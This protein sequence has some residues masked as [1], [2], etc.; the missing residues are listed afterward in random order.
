MKN[1]S[2]QDRYA[3][4]RNLSRTDLFFL[5]VY[6]LK[7]ADADN[8]WVFARCREMQAEPNGYLDLWAREHYKSSIITF[9]LTIQD[10]LNNPDLTVGIFSH[11]RPIAKGFLRQIKSEFERNELLKEWFPDILWADPRKEAPKWSEDEG[12]VVKRQSNPKE[13][14]IEAWGLVDGQPTS[15]HFKLCV[16]DDVVTRE[17]VTTPDMIGKVTEAWELSRN[18]T[19]AGGASRYIGTRYHF[20]DTYKTILDRGAAKPRVY[21]ATID[22]TVNGQPV[23]LSAE[24]LA[25]KRRE[26]GPHT[27]GCLPG[28]APVLMADFREKP[29]SEIKAGDSVVGYEFPPRA[30]TR[31]RPAKVLAV[32]NRRAELLEFSLASG[33]KVTCTAQHKWYTG[34]RGKD[35]GGSDTHNAYAPL[36]NGARP[37]IGG[38]TSH[39]VSLYDPRQVHTPYDERAAAWLGGFYD[40]EGS[41]SG[42]SVHFHQSEKYPDILDRLERELQACDFKFGMSRAERRPGWSPARDYYLRGGRTEHIRFLNIARPAKAAAIVKALFERDAR[43]FNGAKKN[44]DK[45][46]SVRSLGVGKVFNMET[47]TGNY[48]AYGYATKNSQML[49]NPKADETQGFKTEWLRHYGHTRREGVNVCIL[50]DSASE[51]KKSSDYTSMWVLGLNEDQNIYAL[52]MVRDRLNLSQRAQALFGLHRKWMPLAVGY[53]KYGMMADVEFMRHEMERIN[54]RFPIAELGGQMPK[55]DR[56]KRLVPYFEQGRLYLPNHLHRTDYEGSTVDLVRAFVEEEFKAFPVGLHDDMLDSL[57]RMF[58]L[59]PGGLPFPQK[60][61][62]DEDDGE[63]VIARHTRSSVTGY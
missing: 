40:G 36:G 38:Q 62:E 53:E 1:C 33:R 4:A 47:E 59:Y 20:N 63:D 57:S 60:P 11:T 3:R 25:D 22:G 17:S 35:V 15:K 61:I 19:S 49:L 32:Q 41:A 9:A 51:K 24:R 27:F 18:L 23:L 7:R 21:P 26:M 50:V 16:Y 14:T 55:M 46:V 10:I 58:D 28:D 56:I 44:R 52:D 54:Y 31:I 43:C 42:N 2:E 39:L 45:V 48:V 29:I 5:L 34:R 12:I 37:G 30:K 6:G 13:S 8:D